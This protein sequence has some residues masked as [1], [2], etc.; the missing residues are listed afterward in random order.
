MSKLW[1]SIVF[2]ILATR[3]QV[4]RKAS[5][6]ADGCK[7]TTEVATSF[8]F[9]GERICHVLFFV[10]PVPVLHSQATPWVRSNTFRDTPIRTFGCN[11]IN[12]STNAAFAV[13][14]NSWRHSV[15]QSDRL[16]RAQRE[17]LWVPSQQPFPLT[18]IFVSCFSQIHLQQRRS[19][20]SG[21]MLLPFSASQM[22]RCANDDWQDSLYPLLCCGDTNML[23]GLT[24]CRLN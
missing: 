9:K 10:K 23:D 7:T 2:I 17:G 14:N 3:K 1:P 13:R 12:N 16:G 19:T 11:Y 21:L 8:F 15:G 18:L 4:L 5:I 24:L 6:P 22:R 20:F